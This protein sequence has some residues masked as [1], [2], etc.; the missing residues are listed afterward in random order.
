MPPSKHAILGA[1]SAHRWLACTPSAR[2]EAELPEPPGSEAAAEGTLAHAIAEE[3]LDRLLAGKKVATSLRLKRNPL[4]KPVMEEHVGVYTDYILERLTEARTATPDALLLKEERVDFSKW[5]PNGFG[6]ADCILIADGQMQIFDLKYGKGVP[7]D[8]VENPQI[9]L[10]ALG[11]LQA[12]A[13]LYDIDRVMM[14]IIQ[15]RLD[16]TTN[17]SMTVAA[18][19]EWAETMVRPRAE[20]AAK[21]AGD[22]TPGEHCR[23]CRAR[24]ICRAHAQMQLE[25]AKLRFSEPDHEE[26]KPAALSPEEISEILTDVDGLVKWAKAVKDYALDQ[27]VNHGAR[28]PGYKVVEGRSNRVITDEAKAIELLDMAGFT[29]DR[30]TK[31]KG[32]GELEEI[33]G[34]KNLSDLLGELLMKPAGKPVLAKESDKRPALNTAAAVFEA[35]REE[36][37]G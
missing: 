37:E 16:N 10:Y 36:D 34:V 32:L 22:Y 33:V 11:A 27:A 15:P 1:S 18:L 17:E 29:S 7:V 3:H 23:W 4:Y 2:W 6:T 9:R 13:L 24:T 30:V 19:Y 14:H 25:I 12:F 8:A 5:V 35:F 21:G 28:F 26:R 20:T 31:L